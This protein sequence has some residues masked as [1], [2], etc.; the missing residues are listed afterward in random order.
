MFE[1]SNSSV[2]EDVDDDDKDDDDGDN[3]D[4][5]DDDDG[6]D[7]SSASEIIFRTNLLL[8]CRTKFIFVLLL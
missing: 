8:R 2:D 5:G 4:D 6:E 1:S 3:D 7:S